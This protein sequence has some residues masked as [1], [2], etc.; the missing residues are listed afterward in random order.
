MRLIE[1]APG[2]ATPIDEFE[3]RSAASVPLAHGNGEAHVHCLYIGPGG[4]IGAH[5]AGFAQLFLIVVGSGWVAGADG[6][7]VARS[8]GEG[9]LFEAGEL[10]SKGSD[11]GITAIMIQAAELAPPAR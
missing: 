1:F 6:H 7:R 8:T 2:K 5:R 3:S 9:A 4:R 11:T 10:H